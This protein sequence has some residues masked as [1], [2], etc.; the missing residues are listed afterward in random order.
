MCYE[1]V[2]WLDCTGFY[3]KNGKKTKTLLQ[4]GNI[5]KLLGFKPPADEVIFLF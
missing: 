5:G 4:K 3:D 1:S 2:T